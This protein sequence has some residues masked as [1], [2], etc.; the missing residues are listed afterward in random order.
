M[1]AVN[2]Q[3]PLS[4]W[5]SAQK[6]EFPLLGVYGKVNVSQGKARVGFG[7]SSSICFLNHPSVSEALWKRHCIHFQVLQPSSYNEGVRN[8]LKIPSSSNA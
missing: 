6:K 7:R 2:L 4:P 5:L 3:A 1:K 8:N